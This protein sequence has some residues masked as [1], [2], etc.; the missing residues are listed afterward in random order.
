MVN[1]RKAELMTRATAARRLKLIRLSGMQNHRCCYCGTNTWH[2]NI[3]D[4]VINRIK[5]TR[6]TLEH[7]LPRSQGGTFAMY[8][9]AMACAECNGARGDVPVEEFMTSI[10]VPVPKKS[11]PNIKRKQPKSN[12]KRLKVEKKMLNLFKRLMTLSAL[13]PEDYKYATENVTERTYRAVFKGSR[14][15]TTSRHTHMR[16]IRH[17]VE[18]NKMVA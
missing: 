11:P 14:K 17:R 7:L 4:Y 15:P 1:P 13:F 5:G 12:A 10:A 2:P 6:A 3:V 16:Q 18:A 8:N 9:L